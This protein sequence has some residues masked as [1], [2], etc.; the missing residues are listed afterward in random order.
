MIYE[1]KERENNHLEYKKEI[2]NSDENKKEFLK[3]VSG[4]ANASGGFLIIGV[5]EKDAKPEKI[6][7]IEEKMGNQK[8]DEWVNNVLISNINERLRYEIKI[9]ELENKKVVML[10]Y[11]PESVKKPHMVTFHERNAYFIR[12]NTSVNPATHA[13]VREMFEYSKKNIDKFEEFLKQRNLFNENSENFGINENSKKL[14]NDLQGK[15]GDIQKPFLLYSFIPRYLDEN[16][17]NTA[18]QDLLDWLVKNSKG[19]SPFSHVKLFETHR[20]RVH[21]YGIVFPNVF[22]RSEASSPEVFNYYFEI[23]NN[24][25]FDSGI[26]DEV[27]WSYGRESKNPVLNLTRTVGYA[28]LLLNF[29]ERFYKKIDYYDEVILRISVVNVKDFAL[30]GFGRKNAQNKWPEPFQLDHERPPLCKYHQKFKVIQKF[31]V[32]ELSD[33]FIN[34]NVLDIAEQVS[35]AFGETVVKCFDDSGTFN[36]EGMNS[37]RI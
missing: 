2:G 35:R 21:L 9:F 13:E 16:R 18:S 1:R 5:E 12:H 34:K 37:F 25:F 3:D 11:I 15:I 4:F 27:F 10:L 6:T 8:I 22:P 14:F 7:G 17:I 30:G 32:S 36:K 31:I 26:S 20:K 23:L 33:E 28:W 19:I 29:A 24:G